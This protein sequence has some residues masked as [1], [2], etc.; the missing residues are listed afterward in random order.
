MASLS[1]PDLKTK[2]RASA[3]RREPW[4]IVCGGFHRHGG[5]DIANLAL[6][7]HLNRSGHEVVLLGHDFDANISPEIRK[8]KV[9]R[10]FSSTALGEVALRTTG[11]LTAEAMVNADPHTRVIVNGTNCSYGDINWV[12]Y[13]HGGWEPTY[14]GAPLWCR[15]RDALQG[16]IYRRRQAEALRRARLVIANSRTSAQQVIT[17]NAIPAERVKVVYLGCSSD[18]RPPS[19]EERSA[20][21]QW[22]RIRDDQRVVAFIGAVTWDERKGFDTLWRAWQRIADPENILVVAGNGGKLN[23]W[24]TQMRQVGTNNVRMLG[25]TRRVKDVLAAADLL[26]SPS[27]YETFGLNVQEAICH[28]VPAVASRCAGITELFPHSMQ[29]LILGD[30]NCPE[31]LAHLIGRTLSDLNPWKTRTLE[32]R[33]QLQ[34]YTWDDMS[35]RIAELAG[36]TA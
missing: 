16:Q 22:L 3:H 34:A 6:A 35:R 19:V 29:G 2:Y 30:P 25:F 18:L 33:Q 14:A 20:A 36:E 11:K 8:I 10:L 24:Q 15:G 12:H 13:V 21:R 5:M 26:V 28:G 27:R 31:E 1:F 4:L 32:F 17:K 9:P 7:E 23:Y